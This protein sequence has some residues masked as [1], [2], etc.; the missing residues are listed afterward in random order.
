MKFTLPISPD[1]VAHWGLWEA[2]REIYQ[3]ALDEEER[4]KECK[5]SIEYSDGLLRI[6]TS[7]GRLTTESMVLGRTSKRDDPRQRGKFGEGYKLALLVLARLDYGIEILT[8]S[9]RWDALI[10]HDYQFNSTVLNIYTEPNEPRGAV[11]EGVCFTISGIDQEQWDKIRRNIYSNKTYSEIL[12]GPNER[13]RIYVGGLYVCTIKEFHCGYAFA[14]NKIQLDRDRSIVKTFDLAWATSE[15]WTQRGGPRAVELLNAEAPDVQYVESHAAPVSPIVTDHL[16][17]FESKHGY[18]AVPVST[19][20]EIEQATT[21]GVKWVLVPGAVKGLLRMVKSWFVPTSKSPL[22]QLQA[23][24]ERYEY[25]MASD[26]KH[27]LEA[28]IDSMAGNV[29]AAVGP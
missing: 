12:E 1:Y 13:G 6:A 18:Q 7:K 8:G 16:G 15:L 28:I 2:V 10:E 20:E 26:M 27:D 21:A 22:E 3:N 19:Q 9:E 29:K 11:A 24:R 23:F 25:R 17:W 14:S 5:S 4:D